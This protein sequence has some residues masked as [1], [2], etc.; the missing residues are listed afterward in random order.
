MGDRIRCIR[1]DPTKGTLAIPSRDP[2]AFGLLGCA[3]F[4][5]AVEGLTF[6]PQGAALA[7]LLGIGGLGM[8]AG[9]SALVTQLTGRWIVS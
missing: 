2:A 4:G 3:L 6:T 7:V 9:F 8:G 1:P 5:V